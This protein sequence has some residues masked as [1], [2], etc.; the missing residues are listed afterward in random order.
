MLLYEE[1]GVCRG[2]GR[3]GLGSKIV[4]DYENISKMLITCQKE[5]LNLKNC[6]REPP[7]PYMRKGRMQGGGLEGV[8]VKNCLGL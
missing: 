5:T 2:G 8:G 3:R 6:G 1:R 7:C 4:F